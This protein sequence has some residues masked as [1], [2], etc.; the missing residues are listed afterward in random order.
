MSKTVQIKRG[1]D[2]QKKII[3]PRETVLLY[4]T[5]EKEKDWDNYFK[6]IK[7]DSLIAAFPDF[8]K[9]YNTSDDLEKLKVLEDFS[10]YLMKERPDYILDFKVLNERVII[11]GKV[12]YVNAFIKRYMQVSPLRYECKYTLE[13]KGDYWLVTYFDAIVKKGDM[14]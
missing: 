4:L 12:A 1:I 8:V 14:P 3:T 7:K 11:D 9:L 2:Y 13:K 6:Y 5:A 10:I